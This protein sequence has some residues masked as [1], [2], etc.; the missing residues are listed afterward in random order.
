M[1]E[2]DET[3]SIN[4]T[5]Q[6]IEPVYD[7][8]KTG[9]GYFNVE[10]VFDNDPKAIV[11]RLSFVAFVEW[12]LNKDEALFEY[13]KGRFKETD[14][15]LSDVIIDLYEIGFD[16]DGQVES[17]F[18][19]IKNSIDPKTMLKLMKFF[20]FLKNFGLEDDQTDDPDPNI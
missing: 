15:T 14:K 2:N 7:N 4:I 19:F 12:L 8:T 17:Y 3:I 20:Q 9:G 18:D 10:Y 11:Y 5:I 13:I 6:S 1:S 16:V